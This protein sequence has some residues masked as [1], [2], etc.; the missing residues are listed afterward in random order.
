[1][2][3]D[4]GSTFLSSGAGGIVTGYT[5]GPLTALAGPAGTVTSVILGALVTAATSDVLSMVNEDMMKTLTMMNE[6]ID[7]VNS[8]PNRYWI[9]YP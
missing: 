1:V 2:T 3:I 4:V 8:N 9:E 7:S 6:T 5:I